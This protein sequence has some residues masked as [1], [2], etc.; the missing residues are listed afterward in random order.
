MNPSRSPRHFWLWF[1][2]RS[3]HLGALGFIMN[4][5]AGI[6]LTFYLFLHLLALGQLAL[7]PK[8]YDHFI[9]LVHHPLFVAGEYLVVI[10]G[11][12][13]GLNGL[14]VAFTSLGKGAAYQKPLFYGLM[15]LA[16]GVILYFGIRMLGG[17]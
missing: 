16:L 13:H 8:A 12:L 4:R 7:G 5:V 6:G 1:D 14:R 3:K 17:G 10:G 15:S 9:A 2:P 11:M